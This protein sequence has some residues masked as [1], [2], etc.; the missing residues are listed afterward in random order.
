MTGHHY[1]GLIMWQNNRQE[2]REMFSFATEVTVGTNLMFPTTEPCDWPTK[3]GHRLRGNPGPWKRDSGA[4]TIIV[5]LA[6]N[7]PCE[8]RGQ[9]RVCASVCMFSIAIHAVC[10]DKQAIYL[11]ECRAPPVVG[12]VKSG[13]RWNFVRLPFSL[14][15]L[16]DSSHLKSPSQVPLVWRI[17]AG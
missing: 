13:T 14:E 8:A 2:D 1:H 6:A 9:R 3:P 5:L 12:R 4:V 11:P 10:M 7:K 15:A 17:A 16:I